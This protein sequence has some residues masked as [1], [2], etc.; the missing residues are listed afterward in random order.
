MSSSIPPAVEARFLDA[1]ITLNFK[2]PAD[3][4]SYGF[5]DPEKMAEEL[6][7]QLLGDDLLEILELPFANDELGVDVAVVVK[8]ESDY[9]NDDTTSDEVTNPD[10]V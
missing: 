4:E 6:K 8:S 1:T 9:N 10:G 3:A 7:K 5:Y 2:T